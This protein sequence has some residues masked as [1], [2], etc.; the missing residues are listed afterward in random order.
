MLAHHVVHLKRQY[1]SF[2]LAQVGKELVNSIFDR[3]LRVG[4]LFFVPQR[5]H[6]IV[7]F[8]CE[9]GLDGVRD[10]LGFAASSSVG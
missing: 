9:K 7:C 3:L 1:T 5:C 6:C 4:E 2:I 10:A 8:G